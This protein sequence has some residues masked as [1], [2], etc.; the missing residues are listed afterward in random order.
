MKFI[1]T[2]FIVAGLVVI[3]LLAWLGLA[4]DKALA[5]LRQT[6]GV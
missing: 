2:L 4:P 3:Y 5:D 1:G 6:W